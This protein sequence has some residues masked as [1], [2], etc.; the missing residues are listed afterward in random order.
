MLVLKEYKARDIN[1]VIQNNYLTTEEINYYLTECYLRTFIDIE[2]NNIIA[3]GMVT[4]NGEIGLLT[5]NIPSKYIKKFYTL[6]TIFATEAFNFSNKNILYTG[7]KPTDKYTRW[8]KYL[9]F[10]KAPITR[11][12]HAERGWITYELPLRRWVHE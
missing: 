6:L 12:A 4:P 10:T 3:I 2:L 8:I 11:P 7:I 5:N 9:D 1:T